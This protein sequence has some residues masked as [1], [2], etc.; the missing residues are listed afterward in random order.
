VRPGI[1]WPCVPT[2]VAEGV[3]LLYIA[4][5]KRG[6]RF[7]KGAQSNLE[8]PV[9]QRIEGAEWQSC[10]RPG[11]VTRDQDGWLIM[12]DGD[13]GGRKSNLDRRED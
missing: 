9:S 12:L 5:R 8:G 2:A 4:D 13:D 3:Q 11:F 6:L 1:V 10:M 7:N